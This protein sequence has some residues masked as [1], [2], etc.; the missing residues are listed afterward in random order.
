M[1]G[2]LHGSVWD[3]AKNEQDIRFCLSGIPV[4][5]LGH[6]YCKSG[7]RLWWIA[8]SVEQC[9]WICEGGTG[10]HKLHAWFYRNAWLYI[11][12]IAVWRYKTGQL[13][14]TSSIWI[15][16]C[17]WWITKPLSSQWSSPHWYWIWTSP[18]T[19]TNAFSLGFYFIC[20]INNLKFQKL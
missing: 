11:L 13:P 7:S 6:F 20:L 19:T 4:P 5:S 15:L 8:P 2:R 18:I 1:T 10:V 3:H 9:L 17:D 12:L 14:P 16:G